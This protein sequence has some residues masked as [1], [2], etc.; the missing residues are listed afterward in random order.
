MFDLYQLEQLLVFA[1]CGTLSGAAEKL[2][3]SQTAL[4]RSMQRLEHEIQ[5]PL[6]IRHKN[7][8][9][10]NENG[11]LAVEYARKVIEQ[12]H[13]MLNGI[14][15]Y[16]RKRHTITIG[17]C[18]PAPLWNIL[19]ILSDVYPAMTI[20]S[21]IRENDVLVQGLQDE[22]YQLIVLPYMLEKEGVDCYKYGEEQLFFSLPPAH[23]LSGSK[24]LYFQDLNGE[25]MLL[26]SQIG[27]WKHICEEKMPNTRFLVQEEASAF[28]E[29]VKA[30]ALP[31]FVS[32][33]SI[34]REREAPNRIRIPIL[35]EEANITYYLLYQTKDR[36]KLNPLLQKLGII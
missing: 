4:S 33:L 3:L 31:S 19:P 27:F 32:D 34:Q 7:K 25:T 36:K 12:A 24:G 21:D 23:P 28:D 35:D 10:L 20:S 6:F 22:V 15:A 17:S 9:E 18:A 1:E 13:D 26:L 8:I 2:L 29:L 16:D 11:I 5:V 30:S 14:R